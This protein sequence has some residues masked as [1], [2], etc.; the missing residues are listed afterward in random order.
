[1]VKF[2]KS[3]IVLIVVLIFFAIWFNN[4]ISLEN[5]D[6]NLNYHKMTFKQK[7][8]TY[9]ID[10][11]NNFPTNIIQ[12]YFKIQGIYQT[13]YD[14][15]FGLIPDFYVK[16]YDIFFYSILAFGTFVFPTIFLELGFLKDI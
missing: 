3:R 6:P 16:T 1:M 10:L 12:I 13:A 7:F 8:S 11:D 15:S 9:N 5:I 14:Y 2:T 4:L